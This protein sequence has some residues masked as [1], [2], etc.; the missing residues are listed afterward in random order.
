MKKFYEDHKRSFAKAISFRLF[1]IVADF[2]IIVLITKRY[3]IAFGVLLFS[4]I[5]S[6]ILYFLHER[7]W[8][9][10]HWG[11]QA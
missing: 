5:S 1:I 4:N 3:D 10:I 6:T 2:F 9:K 7:I 8:N 11:R